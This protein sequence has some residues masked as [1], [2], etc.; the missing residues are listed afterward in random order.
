[1]LA[2]QTVKRYE[3]L[4]RVGLSR[5]FGHHGTRDNEYEYLCR[6]CGTQFIGDSSGTWE[7]QGK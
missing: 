6:A 3:N 7:K 1:M 4:E 5:D 2:K